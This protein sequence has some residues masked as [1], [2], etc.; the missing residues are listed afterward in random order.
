MNNTEHEKLPNEII[1][2]MCRPVALI[3][4]AIIGAIIAAACL[5]WS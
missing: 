1:A 3:C 2:S 4:A 5:T